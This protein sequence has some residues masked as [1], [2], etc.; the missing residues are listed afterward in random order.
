MIHR[1]NFASPEKLSFPSDLLGPETRE[2][3]GLKG[4]KTGERKC[5]TLLTATGRVSRLNFRGRTLRYPSIVDTR[6]EVPRTKVIEIYRG[7][8]GAFFK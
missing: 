6:E 2:D 7:T 8:D 4:T 1:Q 5:R 3:E